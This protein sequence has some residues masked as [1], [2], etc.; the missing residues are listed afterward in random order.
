M[1]NFLI[2][3][4]LSTLLSSCFRE[5]FYSPVDNNT[6]IGWEITSMLLEMDST[7]LEQ[8]MVIKTPK[9]HYYFNENKVI[10]EKYNTDPK[11]QIATN[12]DIIKIAIFMGVVFMVGFFLGLY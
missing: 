4:V 10:I 1:K 9:N 11:T 7:N 3:I 8:V 12:T 2:I 5:K 6:E